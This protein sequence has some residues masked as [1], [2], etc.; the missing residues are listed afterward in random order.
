MSSGTRPDRAPELDPSV[1]ALIAALPKVELH[2]HLEGS[3]PLAVARTLARRRGITLPGPLAQARGEDAGPVFADFRAFIDAYL[4]ISSTLVEAEDFELAVVEVA[5]VLAAQNVRYVEMTVT[6]LTHVTRGVEADLVLDGLARGRARARETHGVEFAW[7]F[8]IVRTLPDQ[9]VPTLELALRAR[10]QG[11]VGLGLSGPEARPHDVGAL[12]PVF[13]RARGE[14]LASLP[15]AGEMA[16]APSVARAVD[17]LGAT[18][19][20]HGVR[21][22]E[23]PALVERLIG[24]GIALEV[25]PSSNVAL[26]VV[27]GLRAHPL[28]DLMRAGLELS[29]ASDDPPLFGT[30]L[31]EEY[32]RCA[33]AFGFDAA[34]IRRLAAAAV[35][36]ACL[37]E[38]RKAALLAAQAAV[39]TS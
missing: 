18:R 1:G 16:G 22:L 4:A 38:E 31:V 37:P 14:G 10:D 39:V 24:L 25:C 20:G 6:P 21:C 13:E 26:G 35:R 2:V 19:I 15:H 17:L 33:R 32:R 9:A 7:V 34:T 3:I 36:H 29:L 11:V 5:G 30:S 28:P 27:A 23:D 12:A 8:D